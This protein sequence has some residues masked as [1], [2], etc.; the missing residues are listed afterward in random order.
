MVVDIEHP[1]LG[2]MRALGSPIK[3]SA[4]PPDVR[5]PAPLLGAHTKDV[6]LETGFSEDE[7]QRL[8][9]DGVGVGVA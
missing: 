9:E 8:I 5:R 2:P 1:T 7:I 6:L 3:M 4:T